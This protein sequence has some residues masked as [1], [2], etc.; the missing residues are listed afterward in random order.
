MQ[1]T[2]YEHH[3]F[4]SFLRASLENGT[5]TVFLY[6]KNS[7]KWKGVFTYDELPSPIRSDVKDIESV[8]C[9][10]KE[11]HNFTIESGVVSLYIKNLR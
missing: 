8:F 1:P 9:L 10:F 2:H 6:G 11:S 7:L 3:C 4:E 5:M